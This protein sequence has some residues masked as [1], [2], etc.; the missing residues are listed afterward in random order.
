MKLSHFIAIALLTLGMA[1]CMPGPEPAVGRTQ[2]SDDRDQ[3]PDTARDHSHPIR[4]ITDD[5]TTTP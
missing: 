3:Q 2:G 4:N 5:S 1:A